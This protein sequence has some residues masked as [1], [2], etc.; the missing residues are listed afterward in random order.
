[1]YASADVLCV[2]SIVE[3]NG[4]TEGMPTVILEASA[5]ATPSVATSVGGINEFIIDGVNGLVV[6]PGDAASLA[7]AIARLLNSPVLRERLG[8]AA[9]QS[10][11]AY[12]WSQIAKRFD[13][14]YGSVLRNNDAMS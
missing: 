14:L 5:S 12:D 2:P 7:G 9:L 13:T 1:M 6:A 11:A 4:D 3:A 8:R 10:V